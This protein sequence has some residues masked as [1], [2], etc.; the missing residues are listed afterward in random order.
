MTPAY[1]LRPPERI[2]LVDSDT[3]GRDIIS[4][5][6]LGMFLGCQQ[7]FRWHYEERLRPAVTVA[8]LAYGR[9]F[10]HA[11]EVGDPVAGGKV[12]VQDAEAERKRAASS[13][14]LLAPSE[15]DTQIGAQIVMSAARAYLER[16]GRR[17]RREL[18]MR[19]RIRNPEVGGRY[20]RTHDLLARVD[21]IDLERGVLIEDKLTGKLDRRSLSNR[22]RLDRQVSIG[23][24]LAWRCYG[25]DIGEVKYRVTV[26]PQIRRRQNETHEQ[27][28]KRIEADYID[29][30]DF[31]L[32]EEP[33]T[34]THEDFLRL[35]EELWAW[36]ESIRRARR[37]GVWPRNVGSCAEFGGCSFLSLCAGEPGARHQF[38]ARPARDETTE[39]MESTAV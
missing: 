25:V 31:Y 21:G 32:H 39:P 10:A 5:T 36:A 22:L 37:G 33:V 2:N 7:R 24:Y 3:G 26:K 29:R 13:P 17:E 15:E 6:A 30:P 11:T 27:F 1:S 28:L 23:C 9:A 38:V 16:Y 4:H 34:R 19:A 35:E 18:T 14:W 12:F 20:S 8:P